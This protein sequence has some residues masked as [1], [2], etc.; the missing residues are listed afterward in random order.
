MNTRMTFER[1]YNEALL[2]AVTTGHT[3]AV[4]NVPEEGGFLWVEYAYRWTFGVSD[5]TVIA[6]IDHDGKEDRT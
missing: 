5:S 4:A 2:H 1:A 6:V 3:T